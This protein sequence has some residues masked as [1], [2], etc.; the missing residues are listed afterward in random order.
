LARDII[1]QWSID[2]LRPENV[3]RFAEKFLPILYERIEDSYK[4]VEHKGR[5]EECKESPPIDKPLTPL[6]DDPGRWSVDEH[7]V[8]FARELCGFQNNNTNMFEPASY[9]RPA[10]V[11]LYLKSPESFHLVH[12]LPPK[13]PS[14]KPSSGI[15]VNYPVFRGQETSNKMFDSALRTY[16]QEF[17]AAAALSLVDVK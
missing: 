15:N 6:P 9:P 3:K 17:A 7:L 2:N 11:E 16:R 13:S 4:C 8:I 12:M 1:A 5:P 14:S 10:W